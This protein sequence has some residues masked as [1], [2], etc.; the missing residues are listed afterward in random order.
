MIP[1]ESIR[2]RMYE[3]AVLTAVALDQAVVLGLLQPHDPVTTVDGKSEYDSIMLQRGDDLPTEHDIAWQLRML[4]IHW[5]NPNHFLGREKT[6]G[7]ILRGV[8]DGRV[9]EWIKNNPPRAGELNAP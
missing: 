8:L 9:L 3:D 4:A 2:Q 5:G 1:T 6:I 7:A